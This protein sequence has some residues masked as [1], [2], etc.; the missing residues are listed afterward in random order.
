MCDDVILNAAWGKQKEFPFANFSF[1]EY[2][3]KPAF[4]SAYK[5]PGGYIY[6]HLENINLCYIETLTY[7]LSTAIS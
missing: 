3:F 7:S 4:I 5:F 2:E 1:K 6:V